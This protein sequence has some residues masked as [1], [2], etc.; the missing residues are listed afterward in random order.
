[1]KKIAY[2]FS[3]VFFAALLSQAQT[4]NQS[5]PAQP[6]QPI[7]AGEVDMSKIQQDPA[8]S[9]LKKPAKSGDAAT[10]K[11]SIQ[12]AA[13]K[14]TRMAINEKGVP[15]SKDTKTT[16]STPA[17]EQKKTN[18]GQPTTESK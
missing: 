13:P 16:S 1:M 4:V 6:V 3:L 14:S 7:P 12:P 15:A 11:G 17:K 5:T 18:P 10:E 9:D 8:K 2:T